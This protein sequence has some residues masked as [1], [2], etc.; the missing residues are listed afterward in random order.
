MFLEDFYVRADYRKCG[1]GRMIF[2]ATVELARQMG[3]KKIDYHVLS[4]NPAKNFYE[5]MGAINRNETENWECF[6]YIIEH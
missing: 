5:K 4:W 2:E 6:R 3:A 1:V